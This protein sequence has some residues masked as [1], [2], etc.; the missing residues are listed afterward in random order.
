MIRAQDFVDA[1]ELEAR[2]A[3]WQQA[4]WTV[5]VSEAE[6]QGVFRLVLTAGNSS[7]KAKTPAI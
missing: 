5:E 7:G 2:K 6:T 1:H 4:A 3:G